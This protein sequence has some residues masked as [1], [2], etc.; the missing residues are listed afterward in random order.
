MDRYVHKP[1]V[2]EAE[3]WDGLT[4]SFPADCTWEVTRDG[5]A[6]VWTARQNWA[7]IR[8]G[9]WLIRGIQGCF[10][11]IWDVVFRAS[12]EPVEVPHDEMG[13]ASRGTGGGDGS[14]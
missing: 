6:H 3:R 12:Y 4:T 2:V 10:Y 8:P 1:T 7:V 11:P 9:D 5:T 13:G 14:V